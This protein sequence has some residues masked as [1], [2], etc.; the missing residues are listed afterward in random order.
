MNILAQGKNVLLTDNYLI[1]VSEFIYGAKRWAITA[2]PMHADINVVRLG[3]YS[4]G[5]EAR[6][7]FDNLVKKIDKIEV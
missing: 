3:E 5:E 6:A 1:K 4:T 2:T 7:A